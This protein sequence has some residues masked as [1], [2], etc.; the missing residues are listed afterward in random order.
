MKG[1]SNAHKPS[2]EAQNS[3]QPTISPTFF[4]AHERSDSPQLLDTALAAHLVTLSNIFDFANAAR[5]PSN[6]HAR[7]RIIQ[8]YSQ[9]LETYC[10]S[11][12][13]RRGDRLVCLQT[14]RAL[15]RL[16]RVNPFEEYRLWLS[17]ELKR[18]EETA[19][20]SF[21]LVPPTF[22]SGS[23]TGMDC[24]PSRFI[25]EDEF[26]EPN[27]Y[28]MSCRNRRSTNVTR[29][30]LVSPFSLVNGFCQS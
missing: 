12:N 3:N 30:P 10:K 14:R 16:C 25:S 2:E 5:I 15:A 23:G 11:S 21:G 6:C 27:M 26:P 19:G 24:S 17:E 20:Q 9:E 4:S 22:G 8:E 28:V 1:R 7:R 13:Q 18:L 29:V